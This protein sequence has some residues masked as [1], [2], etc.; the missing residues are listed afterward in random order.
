MKKKSKLFNPLF[1][2]LLENDESL[3]KKVIHSDTKKSQ[4]AFGKLF[5]RYKDKMLGY[6][7]SMVKNKSVA[8]ELAHEIFLKA[9]KKRESYDDQ[10]KFS[11]WIWTIARNTCLDYL[12]KKKDYSLEDIYGGSSDED[13]TNY[14]DRIE[15]ESMSIEES[16]IEKANKEII[17]KCLEHMKDGQKEAIVM[18]VF[19]EMSHTEMASELKISEQAV[20]SLINR[21]KV[22]LVNCVQNC[23]EE[24][25]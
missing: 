17:E 21:A 1:V 23:L 12:K 6:C 9:Y 22:S 15:D 5:H 20:K 3:M 18:R 7:I 4:D 2:L 14:E 16:L 11:T 10:Y 25:G 13:S 8:E 19:S 24:Q